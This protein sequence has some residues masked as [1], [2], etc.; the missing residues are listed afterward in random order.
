MHPM[1]GIVP[2]I[3]ILCIFVSVIIVYIWFIYK[4]L[5]GDDSYFRQLRMFYTA[6]KNIYTKNLSQSNAFMQLNLNYNEINQVIN[7]NTFKNILALLEKIIYYYDSCSDK[8][9]NRIFKCDKEA[10]VRDF[11]MDM[12][13]YIRQ[14][15]P[16]ISAPQKEADFMYTIKDA[17]T[18]HNIELGSKALTQLSLEIEAKEKLLRKTDRA[19]QRTTILSIV[20]I[21]LTVLFGLL[22]LLQ[23]LF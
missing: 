15:H 23:F 16:F 8:V 10:D 1:L 2:S 6:I 19:N 13:C 17:L 20:G 3:L 4:V 9:F 5:I 14:A 22:S 11:I 21:L 7:N 12:C 18:D